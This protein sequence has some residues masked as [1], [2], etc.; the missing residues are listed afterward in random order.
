MTLYK[1]VP[2][3]RVVFAETGAAAASI[4]LLSNLNHKRERLGCGAKYALMS[5]HNPPEAREGK[6]ETEKAANSH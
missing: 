5:S 3:L 6:D 1:L 2:L 4:T